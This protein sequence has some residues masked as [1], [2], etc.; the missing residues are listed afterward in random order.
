MIDARSIET[1]EDPHELLAM[2]QSLIDGLR[3]FILMCDERETDWRRELRA[4]GLFDQTLVN[5]AGVGEV[6]AQITVLASVDADELALRAE[7]SEARLDLMEAAATVAFAGVR[8]APS[9]EAPPAK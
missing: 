7:I 9:P 4:R 3:S 2:A 5:L 8:T 6:I 1:I